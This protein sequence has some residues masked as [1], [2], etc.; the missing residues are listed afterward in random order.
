MENLGPERFQE[1]CQSLITRAYPSI[2]CLPVGQPDGGRD[3]WVKAWQGAENLIIFQVKYSRRPQAEPSPHEWIKSIASG[4]AKKVKRLIA[5]GAKQYILITN[6]PGTAHLKSG[7][8]D[9]VQES[10]TA[11]LGIAAHCWWRDDINRRLDAAYDLK[12]TYPELM[13]GPDLIRSIIE[14]GLGEHRQ[15]RSDAIKIFIRA[16]YL[17]DQDVRF[18]QVELQNKLL[19]LFVDVPIGFAHSYSSDR[20]IRDKK[21]QE[22]RS[23]IEAGAAWM[24]G[25]DARKFNSLQNTG[26]KSQL[27]AASFLLSRETQLQVPQLVLEGA[28][29]QGKSTITQYVCQ[30]HRM[31]ILGDQNALNGVP[32]QHRETPIKLPFKVDLRDLATWLLKKDPFNPEVEGVPSQWERSLESFLTAQVRYFSGGASFSV[33]DLHAVAKL[34]AILLVFD[35]LDEIADIKRRR[36]IVEEVKKGVGRLKEVSASLQSIVTSRPA[37]FANSPGLPDDLFPYFTLKSLDTSLVEEYADKWLR[38]REIYNREAAEVKSILREKIDQPHLRELAR[39]PM[40]LAILLSLIHSRGTS[41]PDKRTALYDSYMELFF[42]RESTKSD[43]VRDNRDLLIDIHRYLAWVLHSEAEQGRER[44]K[45]SE[46]RLRALLRK[47]LQVEGHDETLFEQ[48]FSGMIERVVAIVSR[49]QGVYEFEVQP[50]REYFAARHLYVTAPYSPPGNEKKGTMP[51]RFDAI[52]RNFYWLNVTRF[53]AGCLDKGELPALVDRLQILQNEPNYKYTSHPRMLAGTLL[54]DWVFTQQPHQLK[55]VINLLLDDTGMRY[56]C[57]GAKHQ[58][59]ADVLTLPEKCGRRELIIKCFE[60]LNSNITQEDQSDGII[61]LILANASKTEILSSWLEMVRQSRRQT[62]WLRYGRD[63]GCLN[64]LSCEELE[65]LYGDETDFRRL[66]LL[67]SARR[68]DYLERTEAHFNA[69]I[70]AILEK[71]IFPSHQSKCQSLLELLCLG[72]D[73]Y[74]YGAAFQYRNK[75]PLRDLLAEMRSEPFNIDDVTKIPPLSSAHKLRELL[76][77]INEQLGKEAA[78]W[79]TQIDP[80]DRIVEHIRSVWGEARAAVEM[81][82]MGAGVR[83]ST[84]TCAEFSDFHNSSLSLCRRV[85]Y[86]RLRSG[87]KSWWQDVFDRSTSQ[88]EKILAL[89]TFLSWSS[90]KTLAI[91]LPVVEVILESV[92][93]QWFSLM[94]SL[95]RLSSIVEHRSPLLSVE[96]LPER[97]NIKTVVAIYRRVD[98]QA[99][100]FLF[101]KFLNSYEGEDYWILHAAQSHLTNLISKTSTKIMSSHLSIISRAYKA[102]VIWPQFSWYKMSRDLGRIS[103]EAAEM[104]NQKPA[105]Y[106]DILIFMAER[107]FREEITQKLMPVGDIANHD[108]W[109]TT[110]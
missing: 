107:K 69:A 5:L 106:P 76:S 105:C 63:L 89:L 74:R 80:W 97:L 37:A 98:S 99:Q 84:E 87:N 82:I 38:A 41:L 65:A 43:V 88:T 59:S 17:Q 18:K 21:E 19:D 102:G 78:I 73:I 60:I 3:A 61:R 27:G 94:S 44:D 45:I 75:I 39:N 2:Q 36:D 62:Q 56:L 91:L 24:G 6:I 30:I 16:Q 14:S 58:G 103:V 64:Q 90:D 57:S 51:D 1:F 33:S 53:F 67:M 20:R 47:Y 108:K 70:N 66:K 96:D 28:P 101:A 52:A 42:S 40:Q 10:L 55:Q 93:D 81:S 15:R 110:K 85:R 104:I 9:I 7:S 54:A 109:F 77:T 26:V 22:F 4:E 13:T 23:I 11:E 100:D 12:W 29:G 68:F 46:E 95:H 92:D 32:V 34:S 35:G 48:L 72:L 79:A 31:R 50:L 8:I 25:S 71:T 83:S 49:V 86:G